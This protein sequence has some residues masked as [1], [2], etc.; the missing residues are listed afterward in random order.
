MGPDICANQLYYTCRKTIIP[1]F[2][3]TLADGIRDYFP[4]YFMRLV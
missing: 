1:I 2:T 4:T 3:N